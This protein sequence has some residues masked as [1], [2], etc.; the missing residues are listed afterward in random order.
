[1]RILVHA[2][3]LQKGGALQ[4]AASLL[5]EFARHAEYEFHI[6]AGPPLMEAAHSLLAGGR[7][8]ITTVRQS[9][10][11]GLPAWRAFL[12]SAQHA[13]KTWKPDA[14]LTV[15]GPGLW[16]PR[17]PHLM[18]FANGL[19]LFS[20]SRFIREDWPVGRLA[21]IR[22]A[23]RRR[24]LLQRVRK[25]A[26]AWWVETAAAKQTLA[27]AARISEEKIA[28]IPNAVGQAFL[29]YLHRAVVEQER[30][31]GDG[32]FRVLV[33]G[34]A[35]PNKN[36]SLIADM[37]PLVGDLNLKF[38]FTLPRPDF[39]SLFGKFSSDARLVNLGT[40]KPGEAPS[41]YLESDAVLLPSK[42]ET[43]SAVLLEAAAMER[44]L[45]APD[46]PFAREDCGGSAQYFDPWSAASAVSALRLI[47][48][49]SSL[50][51]RLVQSGRE[52]VQ[53]APTAASRAR[54]ILEI[55][56]KLGSKKS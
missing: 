37:L 11:S 46:L 45:L 3:N 32:E 40:L 15:F 2:A 21:R 9:P 48:E 55:L 56:N 1:M 34:A 4:V 25:E 19:Y 27:R 43:F 50:R 26:D 23:L 36:L 13:E 18:G 7:L 17:V 51:M 49:D 30:R 8:T 33:M 24:L 54:R 41:A 31:E 39:E 53:S 20:G 35:Y 12:N 22:Y 16:R 44:P 28:V 38:L 14:V 10:T 6:L 42:L 29:P 5:E 52:R 47:I